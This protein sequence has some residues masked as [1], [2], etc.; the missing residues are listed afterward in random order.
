M[1]QSQQ[2]PH[3]SG[4][5]PLGDLSSEKMPA[6]CSSRAK[7]HEK[8]NTE[9]DRTVMEMQGELPLEDISDTTVKTIWRRVPDDE[10]PP[11][12]DWMND[13]SPHP[14]TSSMA[15]NPRQVR[16]FLP[17]N[18]EQAKKIVASLEKEQPK[19][20]AE[21]LL[22]KAEENNGFRALPDIPP[23]LKRIDSSLAKFINLREP[24]EKLRID[25]TLANAMRPEDFRIRPILLVGS[26][27]VGKTHFALQLAE[28]LGVPTKRWSA[29]GAQAAFQLTGSDRHWSPSSSGLI[30]ET[31]AHNS[32]ASPIFVLDEVDKIS[33]DGKYPV[34]PALLDLLEQETARA[35]QDNFLAMDFDASRIIYVLTANDLNDVPSPILSRVE[36]FEIPAPEPPQRMQIIQSEMKR[37][38]HATQKRIKLSAHTAELLAERTDIDLRQTHRL[39]ADAFASALMAQKNTADLKIPPKTKRT[40]I[41]FM[42]EEK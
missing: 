12:P 28:V 37:L 9:S 38:R 33:T 35:F 26:P 21:S 22:A 25:L 32:S 20:A 4:F 41:G 30:L 27:G 23:M 1:S 5:I 8:P 40:A 42:S 10:A 11:M 36:V 3:T 24:I 15:K 17:D 13:L 16:I 6:T 7:R 19:I 31:L 14:A 18:L 39:I 34:F 2:D 29:G